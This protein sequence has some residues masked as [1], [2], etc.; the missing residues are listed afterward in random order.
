MAKQ[1]NTLN[2]IDAIKFLQFI[3]VKE[4]NI[5]DKSLDGLKIVSSITDSSKFESIGIETFS[6]L[7]RLKLFREIQKYKQMG[8]STEILENENVCLFYYSFVFEQ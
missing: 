1:L 2:S 8:I 3:G 7:E 6:A 5:R 4:E